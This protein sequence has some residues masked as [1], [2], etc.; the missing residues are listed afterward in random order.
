MLSPFVHNLPVARTSLIGR[1]RDVAEVC[2]LLLQSHGRLVTLTGVGGCGKTRLALEVVEEVFGAFP[3]GVWLIDLSPISEPLLVP[4]VVAAGLGIREGPGHLAEHMLVGSLVGSLQTRALLLVLDNCEHLIDACATLADHLLSTCPDLRILATSRE[5]LQIAGERQH[6]VLPL[7]APDPDQSPTLDEL[8]CFPSVQL[9]LERATAVEPRFQLIRENTTAVSRICALLAG[10]PLALELAA[11]QVR[12]LSVGQVAERLDDCFRL[13]RGTRRLAPT[14]QQTLKAA[15]DWSYDLLSITEQTAFRRL[16]VPAGGWSLG[17]AEALCSEDGPNSPA[18]TTGSAE[19]LDVLTRLVDKSLVMVAEEG[20]EAHYRLL[21]PVRQYAQQKLEAS[22]EVDAAYA[23]HTA[24]CIALAERA[25]PEL[26]G[27]RQVEWLRRLDREFDN[28]RAAIQRAERT[29]DAD[30]I[31]RLAG[32]LYYYLWMRRHLREGLR[33]FQTGLT[34]AQGEDPNSDLEVPTS[35]RAKGLFGVIL[36]LSILGENDRALALGPEAVATFRELEDSGGLT[37]LTVVLSQMSLAEGKLREA[38]A[39]AEESVTYGRDAKSLWRLGHAL[40]MLGQVVRRQGDTAAAT[41][42]HRE[43]L[44]LFEEQG[45]RWGVA[46][47][48]ASLASL[49]EQQRDVARVAAL[50]SVRMYWELGDLVSLAAALEYLA[51]QGERGKPEAQIKLF[52][53]AQSLRKSLGVPLPLGERDGLEGHLAKA[54]D[55]LGESR[56]AAIWAEASTMSLQ[57]VISDLL[58]SSAAEPG[59]GLPGQVPRSQSSRGRTPGPVEALTPRE[60]EVALL[61]A[62]DFTDRQIAEELTITEGTA[63]LHVHHILQKLGLRSRAQVSDWAH[64][65]GLIDTTKA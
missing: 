19:V 11:A 30:T 7:A 50:A 64:L 15:L 21:E 22:G 4:K 5:P 9:F 3:D 24:F 48:A 43:A 31:L 17:A 35:L 42:L 52:A 34:L 47:A 39:F 44:T 58:E 33:W 18:G 41:A 63:G 65:Q 12:V 6:R 45:D 60:W 16:S 36:M 49:Q 38:H 23:R 55:D 57:S 27:P 20:G 2:D 26:Q 1:E 13:L 59:K 14:R 53:A 29:G 51:L 25:E 61:V 8:R 40:I 46:Y 54:Q 32:A 28:I 62:R 56:F 37:L 10:I